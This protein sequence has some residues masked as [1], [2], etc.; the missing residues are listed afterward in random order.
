MDLVW[1]ELEFQLSA[2]QLATRAAALA[3]AFRELLAARDL[4]PDLNAE[5]PR[6]YLPLAAWLAQQVRGD[7][8]LLVGINGAQGS[9]KSTL[10]TLL[11]ELLEHGLGLRCC[12]V[13]IDDLYLTRDERRSLAQQ[14]HPLL[15]TRGVPGT[16]DVDLGLQLFSQLR[17]AAADS[18][19]PLPRFDKAA[20]ERAPQSSRDHFHGRPDLILFEGWC[21]GA[22]AQADAELA[23][24]LNSLEEDEDPDG[25]WRGFVNQRLKEEYPPLFAE[26]DLLLMLKIP[27]WELVARWRGRQEQQLAALRHGSGVMDEAGLRRFI[28]HYER[29]TRYQLAEMPRRADLV[30]RLDEAQRVLEVTKKAAPV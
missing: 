1:P 18:C 20:D 11:A 22:V 29:L 30:L 16:H 23:R 13:S 7:G 6:L 27:R 26:L 19:T 21:V 5:L 25:V 10:C 9:G 2:P 15:A 14:V 12:V 8:P 24:P 17:N 3:P 28:M 4:P